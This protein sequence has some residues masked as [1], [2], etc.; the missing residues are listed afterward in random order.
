MG[1]LLAL[2]A[3]AAS[4]TLVVLPQGTAA[5]FV[6]LAVILIAL[7]LA[8]WLRARPGLIAG[9][10][11][12]GSFSILVASPFTITRQQ[13]NAL[14]RAARQGDETAKALIEFFSALEPFATWLM[15]AIALLVIGI[16]VLSARRALSGAHPFMLA[17]SEALASFV[18]RVGMVAAMLYVPMII[19]I[20]YDVLQRKYLDINPA[21]TR[22][23]WYRIFTSTRLQEME[24]HLHAVL[25]LMCLAFA[26]VK[27]AHVRIEIVRENLGQR[28]RVWIELLGCL[29]FLVPYCYVVVLYGV[30]F[31]QRS[32]TILERSS[33][34]TG[35]E[36]RFIIKSFLPLGFTVLALAGAS[37]ALRCI[38]YLFGPPGLKEAA[39]YYAGTHHADMPVADWTTP[40]TRS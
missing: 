18:S 5:V 9:A 35:L 33:A 23:D 28:T 26:Y 39:G 22:T 25:F 11:V 19:I 2:V 16:F 17:E 34:Q 10:A 38:V 36:L 40:Q 3:M 8:A 24:W 7:A 27:D 37:V 12:L 21:F 32:F 15:F 30:E 4:V 20:A 29:L 1:S 14:N 31:A 6:A 13:L